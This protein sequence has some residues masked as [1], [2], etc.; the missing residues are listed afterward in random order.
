MCSLALALM[1]IGYLAAAHPVAPDAIE[2]EPRWRPKPPTTTAAPTQTHTPTLTPTPFVTTRGYC[3]FDIYGGCYLDMPWYITPED[4][5]EWMDYYSASSTAH[6]S[7]VLWYDGISSGWTSES[8]RY[9]TD[10]SSYSSYTSAFYTSY[11]SSYN[12]AHPTPTTTRRKRLAELPVK[13]AAP[14][15]ADKRMKRAETVEAEV[16]ETDVV[17]TEVVECAEVVERI[18][19]EDASKRGIYDTVTFDRNQYNPQLWWWWYMFQNEQQANGQPVPALPR[20]GNKDA[21]NRRQAASAD[22]AATSETAS[23]AEPA[24]ATYVATTP[25]VTETP[26][27]VQATNSTATTPSAKARPAAGTRKKRRIA[28]VGA[29]ASGSSAAFFLARAARVVEAQL[30]LAAGSLLEIVVYD[31]ND[32]IGGRVATVTEPFGGTPLEL[33]ASM[34]VPA[35]M[36][37]RKVAAMF[38]LPMIFLPGSSSSPM[39]MWDGSQVVY[40]N[41]GVSWWDRVTALLRYGPVSEPRQKAAV[42][43]FVARMAK[44]YTPSFLAQ[45]GPVKSIAEFA[46][47]LQLGNEYTSRSAYDWAT[48]KVGVSARWANEM[49]DSMTRS[50]YGADITEVHAGA[51]MAGAAL[52][53]GALVMLGGNNQL[54]QAMLV[55]SGADVRLFTEVVN[56]APAGEGYVLSTAAGNETYDEVF[57]GNPWHL[58]PVAKGLDFTTPIPQQEYVKL[59]VTY[60]GTTASAPRAQYFKRGGNIAQAVLTSGA[61]A[62]SG[63]PAPAFQ[64][65]LYQYS[66][67]SSIVLLFSRGELSDAHIHELFGD[68]ITWTHRKEW[69]AYPLLKPTTAYPPV[70]PRAGFHYLAAMEPWLSTMETQT[71]SAR[72]A[73][74]RA[75][76][77]WWDLGIAACKDA[78]SWDLAC[79]PEPAP[80]PTYDEWVA[81]L[82]MV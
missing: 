82:G 40:S 6:P 26:A 45:R 74:A 81:A 1:G 63:G 61:G 2:V 11:W 51:V 59:H 38:K 10:M 52:S 70:L 19:N 22:T 48:N 71:L 79:E 37:L 67:S 27:A 28:I 69:D 50:N 42:S 3:T 36:N 21:M 32:Y 77:G 43:K 58:S 78:S 55:D 56:I 73:V 14:Q 35:N 60:V 53:E 9:E 72:E 68:T 12:A 8:L 15:S 23:A 49:M 25:A 64:V 44:A 76:K 17:E 20:D 46:A 54:F 18:E 4:M 13:T 47:S 7:M 65:L 34:M 30:G 29:G 75:V 5:Q 62:R 24:E 41:T 80:A 57:W 31:K 66:F 16:A 39:N 33:G